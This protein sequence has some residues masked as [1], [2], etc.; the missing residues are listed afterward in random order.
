MK[1]QIHGQKQV[2]V[3]ETPAANGTVT[4]EVK[5]KVAVTGLR[6]DA[7]PVLIDLPPDHVLEL[8][9]E[10]EG[11]PRLLLRGDEAQALLAGGAAMTRDGAGDDLL[12]LPTHL[13]LDPPA[14]GR[15]GLDRGLLA[16]A[17]KTVQVLKV[18]GKPAAAARQLEDQNPALGLNCWLPDGTLEPLA[19]DT[20]AEGKTWLLFLHGTASSTLEGFGKLIGAQPAIWRQL[21]ATYPG[22]MLA[23]DH[24]TLTED[25]IQNAT[26]LLAALPPNITLHLVSHSRGGLVGELLARPQLVA[27]GTDTVFDPAEVQELAEPDRPAAEAL[28]QALVASGVRVTRFVR[29][30]CP[31][32]GTDLAGGR[33]DR[34]LNLLFNLVQQTAAPLDIDDAVQRKV[35]GLRLLALAASAGKDNPD[36]LPG[37][38]AMAP[39][40]SP[41]LAILNRRPANPAPPQDE[42]PAQD[43]LVVIGGDAEPAGVV[44]RLLVWLADALFQGENDL[45]VETG[46]VGGGTPRAVAPPLVLDR[47]PQVDHSRFFANDRTAQAMLLGLRDPALLRDGSVPSLPE[48]MR[49][50]EARLRGTI[51]S[52]D[53]APF[54]SRGRGTPLAVILPGITGSHLAVGKNRVWVSPFGICAR[55]VKSLAL[56]RTQITEDGVVGLYYGA[57]CDHLAR[58]HEVVAIPYDWRLSLQDLGAR[59]AARLTALL[60][61]DDSRPL[62]IVGHS[63]GGLV[64]RMALAQSP[65]LMR[66]FLAHPESRFL[67]LGTPNGGSWQMGLALL[68]R[69]RTVKAL[70]LL[71][72]HDDIDD[73]TAILREWPG[74]VQLLPPELLVPEPW[75]GFDAEAPS[76]QALALAAQAQ[77]LLRDKAG[78]PKGRSLYVA[79]MGDTCA[80]LL[81]VDG[82]L[83]MRVSPE[84][85]GTVLWRTGIPDGVPVWYA[86]SEHGDL[87]KD[88]Y[89]HPAIAD[90][91]LR[92]TT[93][94]L[95]D[96]PG[97]RGATAA[98]AAT[99]VVPA[100]EV[101][102][103][104]PSGP[105]LLAMAMGASP[106]ALLDRSAPSPEVR[107]T[108]VHGNLEFARHPIL[109]GHNLG[110]PIMGA[111]AALD[112]SLNGRLSRR[113]ARGL[114]PGIIE[115]WDVHVEPVTTTD[116]GGAAGT[117]LRG[118]IVVGLG[119]ASALTTGSLMRT[120]RCGLLAYA[121]AVQQT[122]TDRR[123]LAVS[124][125]LLG[126]GS[127]MIAVADSVNAI[128]N[129]VDQA[130][131]LLET[132]PAGAVPGD[133]P[134]RFTEIEIIESVEQIAVTAWHSARGRITRL[135]GRFALAG[136]LEQ[137]RGGWRRTGPETAPDWWMEVSITSDPPEPAAPGQPAREGPLRYLLVDGRARV[138]AKVVATSR[139]LVGH[140]VSMIPDS[141]G[142]ADPRGLSPGRTLFELLWPAELKQHSIEDR[143][144]RLVLDRETA[145][146]P[147]EMLDDRRPARDGFG[148]EVLMATKPPSVRYGVLR[149][150]L[151]QRERPLRPLGGG[152][153]QALVI[154]DPRGGGSTLPA[155]PGARAEAEAVAGLLE[156]AG[157]GVTRMIGDTA[158][159]DQVI[160]ALF[161]RV[162]DV[163]HVASHGVLD[164]QPTPD[165]PPR[166]GI[167]LGAP[168][169]DVIES[170][171]LAQLPEPPALAFLNCCH[172][173]SIPESDRHLRRD[174]PGLAASLAVE[175]I[176]AGCPAV[177]AC[178]W[179]VDDGSAMRFARTLYTDL[180]GGQNFGAAVRHA[181]EVAHDGATTD[182]TWGAY[183]CYGHPGFALSLAPRGWTEATPDA[184]S[185]SEA[186]AVLQRL[187]TCAA[188]PPAP[189][190]GDPAGTQRLRQDFLATR[191][192]DLIRLGKFEEDIRRNGWADRSDVASALGDAYAACGDI[193]S[194]VDAY[195]RAA[196]AETLTLPVRALQDRFALP[197]RLP[198]DDANELR[199][200]VQA[201]GL[202]NTACGP[203]PQR[204][205]LIAGLHLRLAA[206]ESQAKPRNAALDQALDA[207][208][209]AHDLATQRGSVAA[210]GRIALRRLLA[211]ILRGKNAADTAT[212]AMAALAALP[213]D[214]PQ[215]PLA[216]FLQALAQGDTNAIAAL[217][218]DDAL[219]ALDPDTLWTLAEAARLAGDCLTGS[220]GDAAKACA[221]DLSMLI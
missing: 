43:G 11:A 191:E 20:A 151:A 86:P 135:P 157:Y 75:A 78:I 93:T 177:V 63:M 110:D 5:D 219:Q 44:K 27:P 52:A 187:S 29:V 28:G 55:G 7:L 46:S 42:A 161:S 103:L 197:L 156:A 14:R 141:E 121:D 125:V 97:R 209:E 84:G 41:L 107:V 190:S 82:A 108:V 91:L 131:R 178:G 37:I 179:A 142:M 214:D 207:L 58:S 143:N 186:V 40:S 144:L 221:R 133:E 47:G 218:R 64:A 199:A 193:T 127:G 94:L 188:A 9:M 213:R 25:P 168:P 196:M 216:L 17:V 114:H 136:R 139:R 109:V 49:E 155:L 95:S 89:L 54:L 174:R 169:L 200:A 118:G 68:G 105:Q 208:N 100:T 50:A 22:R 85:D 149:Q 132:E 99:Q 173:G 3:D 72:P 146:I 13:Q 159:P 65:E 80:E 189:L 120:I 21:H 194:A 87:C 35:E 39:D 176:E 67:M 48:Q 70:A 140:Y 206:L 74:A 130:N 45:V 71:S 124:V 145:A 104:I 211:A 158:T 128:L 102:P 153:R 164:W 215:R 195:R 220:L 147:W 138:E 62:H 2:P 83:S 201:M 96:R 19:P 23:F 32:R 81:V 57:L 1:L 117:G 212:A 66:G 16:W 210:A 167:V 76:A 111:E 152:N 26:T 119:V 137:G 112:R 205:E 170:G 36:A 60:A 30:A 172:L 113:N 10:G 79:G 181:R 88:A 15:R 126:S 12:V 122:D 166:T 24:R 53:A 31:A 61:Q 165:Q 90:L 150:L 34:W 160:A 73:I 116:A 101:L 33:L 217:P 134:L 8:Q 92:G 98:V 182:N 129:A 171:I 4:V 115:S 184:A 148:E 183:Q 6:G 77:V 69:T 51:R 180:C 198:K 192:A 106:P 202:L 123:A 162:W 163:I 56:G 38:A 59:L 203:S 154:G 18:D 175:L 185:P 204:L